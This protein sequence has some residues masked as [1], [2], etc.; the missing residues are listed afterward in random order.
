MTHKMI[1]QRFNFHSLI[2]YSI[3]NFRCFLNNYQCYFQCEANGIQSVL[4]D[5]GLT[6]CGEIAIVHKITLEKAEINGKISENNF[7]VIRKINISKYHPLGTKY[8]DEQIFTLSQLLLL[9]EDSN[10]IVFLLLSNSST[11]IFE[12]LKNIISKH[13]QFSKRIILTTQSPVLIYK[14]RKFDPD[15]ICALWIK[16]SFQ[17]LKSSTLMSSILGAIVR[18]L[19]SPV[20]GISFVFVNKEELNL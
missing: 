18:N 1:I 10:I 3:H 19:I 14:L 9:L 2:H 17:Y 12:K 6:A 16:K 13:Q 5:A 20:I 11:T 4:L 15:L 7:D 8:K